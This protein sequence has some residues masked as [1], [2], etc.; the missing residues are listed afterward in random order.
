MTEEEQTA[1]T[2][3]FSVCIALV[4]LRLRVPWTQENGGETRPIWSFFACWVL[5]WHHR[6]WHSFYSYRDR[7][8]RTHTSSQPKHGGPCCRRFRAPKWE[9]D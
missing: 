8:G 2:I 3:V 5:R 9:Q 4:I 6:Y 7:F 1:I